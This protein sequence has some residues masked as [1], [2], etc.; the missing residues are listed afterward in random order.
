[1]RAICIG[2]AYVDEENYDEIRD[3][4]N[5]LQTRKAYEIAF[6]LNLNVNEPLGMNEIKKIEMFLENYQIIVLNG[7]NA[8]EFDY[9]GPEKDKKIVLYLKD[10]H[11]D[12]IKSLPAFLDKYYFCFKCMHGYSVFEN[13]P[14][15]DVCK[16]CKNKTCNRENNEFIKCSFCGVSC[17]SANCLK[18][19][20]LKVCGK[21]PKC[22]VC[23]SFKIKNHVCNGKWCL[24]CKSEVDLDH[25]CYILTEEENLKINKKAIKNTN[26]YIFFDYEAMQTSAGHK[27]N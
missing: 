10:N 9:V 5:N 27:V 17:V 20:R 23:S 1:M 18:M 14:C 12:F 8:N 22:D 4:R 13:H 25:K 6:K 24:Y 2:K 15:N 3:S 19:H 16:K 11:F 7:D 21:I 26:G